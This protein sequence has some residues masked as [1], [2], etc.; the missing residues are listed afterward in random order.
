MTTPSLII[1]GNN[2]TTGGTT[3]VMAA[4]L[5]TVEAGFLS[6]AADTS[7]TLFRVNPGVSRS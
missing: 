2:I 5:E 7:V 3:H 1:V 6:P 4:E